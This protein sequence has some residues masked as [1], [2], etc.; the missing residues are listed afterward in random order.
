MYNVI[1]LSNAPNE[2]KPKA[3]P[4]KRYVSNFFGVKVHIFWEGHKILR[5]LHLTFVLCSASQKYVRW[6]FPKIL[7]PSQN[8]WT[9]LPIIA[10]DDMCPQ[11]AFFEIS[12]WRYHSPVPFATF[13]DKPYSM[14]FEVAPFF[15]Y[16][17]CEKKRK[18]WVSS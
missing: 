6:R 11:L 7:W 1:A 2:N 4:S 9:L 15:S 12:P 16:H 10:Y 18:E 5:N 3:S 13:Y 17:F 14:L 8:I